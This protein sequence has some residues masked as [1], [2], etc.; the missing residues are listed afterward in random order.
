[1][2][3]P[4]S[5]KMS[6]KVPSDPPYEAMA[7]PSEVNDGESETPSTIHYPPSERSGSEYGRTSTVAVTDSVVRQPPVPMVLT[8][9][10]NPNASREGKGKWKSKYICSEQQP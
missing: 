2:P 5:D 10:F 7:S 9:G 4:H 3:I 1:M 8:R 6:E